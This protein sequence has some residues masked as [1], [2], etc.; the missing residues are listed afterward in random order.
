MVCSKCRGKVK[1]NAFAKGVCSIC[2]K[3]FDSPD[4]PA[5]SVCEECSDDRM[6]CSECGTSLYKDVNLETEFP[7]KFKVID[8]QTGDINNEVIVL[9]P[10]DRVEREAIEFFAKISSNPVKE[11]TL[12][13]IEGYKSH[14]CVQ[15]RRCPITNSPVCCCYCAHK[16]GC[17]L[18]ERS[19][20]C[21]LV[22]T[23]TVSSNT[24]C[25][26]EPLV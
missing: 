24:E 4:T 21:G 1:L 9:D 13:W 22:S 6:V 18:L 3:E 2:G 16:G 5:G 26:G 20:M 10:N 23:D 7:K 14:R 19:P 12:D 8:K 11:L 15:G 25:L 17:I